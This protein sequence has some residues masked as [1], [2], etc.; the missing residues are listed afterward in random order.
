MSRWGKGLQR[1]ETKFLILDGTMVAT[2]A[3]ALTVA[4]PG[5]FF[6]YLKHGYV[7][8]EHDTGAQSTE[9]ADESKNDVRDQS[10]DQQA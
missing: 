3:V 10:P 1:D 2:A 8:G 4:H 9:E 5:L 6:P 7:H